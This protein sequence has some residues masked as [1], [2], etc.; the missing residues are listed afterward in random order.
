MMN[1]NI[2]QKTAYLLGMIAIF[3]LV[4][5]L[6]IPSQ[7]FA[8]KDDEWLGGYGWDN[9]Y[10]YDDTPV[11]G[12]SNNNDYYYDDTPVYSYYNNND[13]YYD[14][15]PVYSSYDNYYTYDNYDY[16]NYNQPSYTPSTYTP[17]YYS[18][19][20]YTSNYIPYTPSY[21]PPTYI[22]YTPP[23][24]IPTQTQSQNQSNTGVNTNSNTSNSSSSANASSSNTN[25][26]VNNNVSNNVNNNN[27]NVVVG[28]PIAQAPAQNQTQNLEGSC[29]ISPSNVTI[30][31]EVT[32]S[33]NASGGNGNYTYSW[34]GSDG[35]SS[36]SR[37]FTGRFTTPGTKT[38]T[39]TITSGSQSISRSCSVSV[40]QY[41]Y[42][43]NPVNNLQVYCVANPTNTSVNQTVVWTAYVTG[44]N[45]PFA[46]Y[47]W[48]GTDGLSYGNS[49]SIQ[50][51]YTTGGSK[52]AT[53]TVNS[54]GQSISASCY[55]NI[56]GYI[57]PNVT[58]IRQPTAPAPVS[59]VYLN[60]VPETG[61]EFNAKVAL[62]ALGLI[63]WSAFIGYVLVMRNKKLALATGFA[64]GMH[65]N[66]AKASAS[67]ADRIQAFKLENMRKRGLSK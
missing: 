37:T 55:T 43:N 54:N 25:N 2:K 1:K 41:N 31:Q 58:V 9:G 46:T 23:V 13:Y 51:S 36:G 8:S 38:A 44:G 26:N 53:V 34:N 56:T 16:G 10:Y 45:N 48:Y 67:V 49:Q 19:P 61:I 42:P 57:A 28:T 7:T 11:Y 52:T 50:K 60:Q 27:V 17:S 30:N 47:S 20:Q 40:D 29:Y 59:G 14:D 32:L 18:T 65:G 62:F 21:T 22:P 63:I 4:I 6:A 64:H 5:S 12:Y 3:T 66:G 35:I 15:T 39:V 24:Y 33:A